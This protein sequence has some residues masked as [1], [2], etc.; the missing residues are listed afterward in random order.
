M[1]FHQTMTHLFP[2]TLQSGGKM[3]AEPNPQSVQILIWNQPDVCECCIVLCRN[4]FSPM[5]FYYWRERATTPN[6][7]T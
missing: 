7:A 4:P 6:D 3:G 1:S 2:F 5:R